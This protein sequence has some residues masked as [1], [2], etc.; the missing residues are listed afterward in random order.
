MMTIIDEDIVNKAKFYDNNHLPK[1]LSNAMYLFGDNQDF[2]IIAFIDASANQDGSQG[3]IMTTKA[4]YFL[5]NSMDSFKYE[6]IR[7]LFLVWNSELNNFF[8][9]IQTTNKIFVF[10]NDYLNLDNFIKILAQITG[11]TIDFEMDP[12][13]KVM[14]FVPLILND[15]KDDVYEDLTLTSLQLKQIKDIEHELIMIRL[16][17]QD[18]IRALCRYCLDFFEQLSLASEEIDALNQ[19]QQFFDQK[20]KQEDAQL[21]QAKQWFD[22]MSKNYQQGDTQ[23]YDQLQALMKSLGIDEEVLKNMSNEELDEYVKKMC[24][25]F[26]ISQSLFDKVKDCFS[27]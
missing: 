13:Q 21:T 17:Y 9:K 1:Q 27:H 16:A 25:K 7:K 12:Y 18:E 11:L 5:F 19:A 6:E 4:A 3:L 15:L 26:G 14:Y 2:E 24:Q 8:A 23:M 22:Q 20:S 10:K